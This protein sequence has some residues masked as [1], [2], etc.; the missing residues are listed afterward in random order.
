MNPGLIKKTYHE[1]WL[2]TLLYGTALFVVQIILSLVIP[3]IAEQLPNVLQLPMFRTIMKSLLGTELGN[4]LS[5]EMIVAYIWVHPIVLALP[6]A[7]ELTIFTRLPAGEIDRGTAD[8]LLSW[9]V[10]RTS[11]YLSETFAC[12]TAALALF[13]LALAGNL[14]GRALMTPELRPTP[15]E[16][17]MLICNVLCVYTAV[18]GFTCLITSLSKTRGQAVS[19]SLVVPLASFLLTFA[20]QHY[21]PAEK[22]AFLSILTYYR[23]YYILTDNTFP[24]SDIAILL[25]ISIT[26]W[27][28]ALMI[29]NKRNI[30]TA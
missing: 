17:A 22:I 9:P 21:P 5:E 27:L 6:W 10:S 16:I 4:Q 24:T 13:A 25:T 11:I 23:P 12:L 14:T 7:H 19:M 1:I 26:T 8:I 2:T 30:T 20:V 3:S 18:A 15:T 28:T 29:F